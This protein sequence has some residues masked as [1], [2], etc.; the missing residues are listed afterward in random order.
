MLSDAITLFNYTVWTDYV[1]TTLTKRDSRSTMTFL[2]SFLFFLFF[3]NN[4]T[5]TQEEQVARF[6]ELQ[7]GNGFVGVVKERSAGTISSAIYKRKREKKA[8]K[9]ER[10]KK[11]RT[12]KE[13]LQDM[14]ET[15]RNSAQLSLDKS[16]CP[17]WLRYSLDI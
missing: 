17:K 8:S 2:L 4:E 3:K 9:K 14:I 16:Q 5:S 1:L 12:E 15:H 11:K 10:E 6:V 13:K 7:K